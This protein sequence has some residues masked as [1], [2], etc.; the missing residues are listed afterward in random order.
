LLTAR[1]EDTDKLAGL[2]TGADA[3]L[4]KPFNSQELLIRIGNL[5]DVRRRMRAK[6]SERLTVKPAEVT[7]TSQDRLLMERLLAV[8]ETHIGDVRFSVTDLGREVNMSISQ[9]NRK[10]KAIINQ[11]ASQF[12]RSV[13]MQRALDLLRQDAGSIG[14]ISYQVGFEDPGYFT[15]V[16]KNYFGC[17]PSERAKFPPQ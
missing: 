12:I 7:V 17:L 11:T 3:Y 1:A 10:L 13:R 5:I 2:E 6:F 4:I 9:I 16:F 8:M 15:K 14:E